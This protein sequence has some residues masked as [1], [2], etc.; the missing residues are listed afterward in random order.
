[1]NRTVNTLALPAALLLGTS[2]AACATASPSGAEATPRVPTFVPATLADDAPKTIEII[3]VPK[4]LPLPGQ[5]KPT[6]TATAAATK[7]ANGAPAVLSGTTAARVEPEG[8]R[9]LNAIKVYDYAPGA[10]YQVYAAPAQVTDV[11]LQP[12][13]R[14]VDVSA[15]DTLRWA[16]LLC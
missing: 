12:G 1:M 8:G 15:G 6:P 5:L 13:E 11:A 3:E 7:A 4:P 9:F 2:L 16:W 14:L 10:L